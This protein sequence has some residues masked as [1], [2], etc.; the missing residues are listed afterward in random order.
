MKIVII[1]GGPAGLY[2]GLLLKK[3]NPALDIT[4]LERNPREATYGWGVVFSDRTLASF[5]EAD[6]KTYKEITD[7]FVVWDAIDIRYRGELIRCGGHV[8][9]G[10]AR[11]QLLAILQNRCEELDLA[12]RF[13]T[14]IADL[15]EVGDADMIVAADGVNSLVRQTYEHVFQPSLE[16]GRAKY[17]W[18]GTHK[19]FDSFTFIFR[20]NEHGLFQVHAYPFDGSTSTFIVEC[21]EETWQRAGLDQA[22]E[23]ASIAYCEALFA[24]ELR[25]HALMSNRSRWINF[26]TVRN[27]IWHHNNVVL[28]G[29]SAHTAHFSIGSGT[30]IAME[31]AIAL[32]NAFAHHPT[33]DELETALNDYEAER[34]PRVEGLQ[35]AAH[36]SRT[37]FEEVRQYLHLEPMQF[38]FHLLTRSGRITYDNLRLR[39]P[40]FSEAVD[41]WYFGRTREAPAD[42]VPLVVA[43]PPLFNPAQLRQLTL[44]NRI[45][46]SPVSSYSARE[47]VPDD[48]RLDQLTRW[49]GSGAALLLTEPVAVSP[50]GRIT[51][52]C[53]GLYRPEH[54]D[55]W[56]RCLAA[57][58]AGTPA[59]VALQLNHAGRRGSTR[60]RQEGLDRP[61]RRGNWPLLS[62]SPL[63]YTPQSQT[64]K[65]MDRADMDQVRDQFVGAAR[66]AD[67]AG[68]DML[69][70]HFAHGYLLASFLSPLAN[71][72]GDDYGGGLENRLRF[73]LE[74]FDA[75]RAVWPEAK[76]LSVALPA[77]DWARDG[78]DLEEAIAVAQALKAHGCDLVQV[79]AG[80]TTAE[81]RP[82]FGAG[83][84]TLYSDRVRNAA[85][86]ATMTSGGIS[87][88]DQVN[89]ILAAGR[90]DLCIMDP[91]QLRG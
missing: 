3:A 10:L 7:N 2:S 33:R 20:E 41:R 49:A 42:G 77:T 14:E 40:Y 13:E 58:H 50:E 15:S 67:E 17:I 34:R 79:L 82:V 53:A 81:A 64:P 90:A 51:P 27:K 22:D 43:V 48:A 61:L 16:V 68:F 46:L 87:T 55:A 60:P 39:D 45:V 26:V 23:A 91:P 57:I 18:L 6:Y 37:Y 63:P 86:I 59:R 89:S 75:V 47:G 12:L 30:K 9:A 65:E 76:P 66:L 32:A 44:P 35:E 70:L 4:I 28:L 21:A 69:Q 73:P 56:Q 84:L 88:T 36:E 62:A 80:Q 11:R 1:G 25:G 54:A 8:F 71:Q 83:F 74:V 5:R 38:S 85:G 24:E 52:G 19:V 31:D 78:F 72:R 29:D